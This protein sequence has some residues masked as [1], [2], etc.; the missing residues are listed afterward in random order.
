MAAE[1]QGKMCGTPGEGAV[2]RFRVEAVVPGGSSDAGY[3]A[4]SPD[5][6]ANSTSIRA[7]S[8]CVSAIS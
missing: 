1:S 2:L 3:Q 4:V 6:R 7:V 8:E 5:V